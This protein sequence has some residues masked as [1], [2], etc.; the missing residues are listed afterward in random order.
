M[1]RSHMIL[2]NC[3]I[4]YAVVNIKKVQKLSHINNTRVVNCNKCSEY[5][6]HHG[7][8]KPF[9]KK[10]DLYSTFKSTIINVNECALF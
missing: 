3:K 6:H 2:S 8:R 5:D 1:K 10:R 4:T 9:F 7:K